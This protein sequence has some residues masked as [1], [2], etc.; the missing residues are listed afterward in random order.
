MAKNDLQGTLD[1]LVL[2]TLSQMG[3]LHGYGIVVHIQRASG[4]MLRVEEGSL[5]PALHRMEQSGWI[6]S[7]WALTETK[8]KAKYYKLTAAGRKQ[9]LDAEK[10]FE[11]L[12]QGVRSMLRYA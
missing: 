1:L 5:Y 9:L 6:R 2:K 11:Q 12:V 10:S 7:E 3:E 4:E 8:R